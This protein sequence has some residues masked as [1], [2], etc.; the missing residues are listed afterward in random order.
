[1]NSILKHF[2]LLIGCRSD[3]WNSAMASVWPNN[4]IGKSGYHF[5][6]QPH[7]ALLP[8]SGIEGM[9]QAMLKQVFAHVDE[10]PINLYRLDFHHQEMRPR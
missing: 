6:S 5:T 7:L 9:I 1:M 8:L 3:I 10:L 4:A 2:F